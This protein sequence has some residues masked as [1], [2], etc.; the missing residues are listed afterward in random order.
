MKVSRVHQDSKLGMPVFKIGGVNGRRLEITI[1]HEICKLSRNAISPTFRGE[2]QVCISFPPTHEKS[3]F[4][5]FN[6]GT[7]S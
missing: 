6:K 1:D 5:P 4:T 7:S 2:P 3:C